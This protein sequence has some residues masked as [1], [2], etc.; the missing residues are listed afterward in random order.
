MINNPIV[1]LFLNSVILSGILLLS[2]IVNKNINNKIIDYSYKGIL[3]S[4]GSIIILAFPWFSDNVLRLDTRNVFYLFTTMFLGFIPSIIGVIS[5]T[6]FILVLDGFSINIIA[7]LL[8]MIIPVIIGMIFKKVEKKDNKIFSYF[9]A[10][11]ISNTLSIGAL[12]FVLSYSITSFN[13]LI[14]I[15]IYPI[16]Y[17]LIVLIIKGYT[18]N[19]HLRHLIQENNIIIE[20]AINAVKYIEIY[21]IDTDYNYLA[22][23]NHHKKQMK[24]FYSGKIS[25]GDNFLNLISNMKVKNRLKEYLD[26]SLLGETNNI[27][28]EVNDY[29]NKM[30]KE[31]FGPIMDSAGNIIGV[32]VY[33]EDVSEEYTKRAEIEYYSKHDSLTGLFNRNLFDKSIKKLDNIGDI[34]VIYFDV[35]GLKR[36]NDAFGHLA[37]DKLIKTVADEIKNT[38]SVYDAKIYR[39]GGDEIISVSKL[40]PNVELLIKQIKDKLFSTKI[41]H[42]PISLSIGHTIKQS[43]E[44]FLDALL[45][46]EELMYVDKITNSHSIQKENIDSLIKILHDN[47]VE[48]FEHS[49]R[50]QELSNSIGKILKLSEKELK[51]LDLISKLHDIGKIGIDHDLLNKPGKLTKNEFEIMKRHC[52]IGYQILSLI[53]DYSIIANDVLSHHED[54]DGSGYPRGLKGDKIPLK[55]RIIR[56]VDSYDAMTSD[57]KYRKAL[58][59]EVALKE[60]EDGL[61]TKYDP[62]IGKKFITMIKKGTN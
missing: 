30:L 36:V 48:T 15:L 56:I 61:G 20:S 24:K 11:I 54:Y 55:A 39:I 33:S 50:V 9:I 3:I 28:V 21:V 7:E 42:L 59:K 25:L 6:S 31:T 29:G 12:L 53:Y 5:T 40:L 60:I 22:F 57:R 38:L 62:E 27:T 16:L 37:G 35:N 18:E 41:Y 2:V 8:Y 19:E 46:A 4:I 52:E 26:K 23:N 47:E 1:S 10:G 43:D 32:C 17:P 45:V 13:F 14:F 34:S 51:L 44:S 58:T 49:K